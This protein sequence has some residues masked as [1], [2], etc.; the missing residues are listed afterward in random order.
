L[1]IAILLLIGSIPLKAMILAFLCEISIPNVC[2]VWCKAC[3]SLCKL[4]SE[5]AMTTWSSTNLNTITC[6]NTI[7]Y[8]YYPADTIIYFEFRLR[9]SGSRILSITWRLN[10]E[11]YMR[12]LRRS[13]RLF[14]EL[15]AEFL[16]TNHLKLKL[17]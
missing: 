11:V 17:I 14:G 8:T 2:T 15:T 13:G 7:S 9:R 1:S 12:V 10:I 3:N 5:F 4:S 6:Y 16:T